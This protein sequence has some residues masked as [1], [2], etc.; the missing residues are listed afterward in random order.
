MK[1]SHDETKEMI[2]PVVLSD[3]FEYERDDADNEYISYLDKLRN[4][5]VIGADTIE[6]FRF[7]IKVNNN[8]EVLNTWLE[9][10]KTDLGNIYSAYNQF[11]DVLEIDHNDEYD[12]KYEEFLETVKEI[13]KDGIYS[14]WLDDQDTPNRDESLTL[15]FYLSPLIYIPQQIVDK[16]YV[17]IILSGM[18]KKDLWESGLEGTIRFQR[19]IDT[20]DFWTFEY[21]SNNEV[22]RPYILNVEHHFPDVYLLSETD[23]STSIS[24][25]IFKAF[26]FYTDTINVNKETIPITRATAS[27]DDDMNQF[28][29]EKEGTF[30]E[31]FMEKFYWM[32]I[33][34][35]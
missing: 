29:Y 9:K 34:S 10:L 24:N 2:R 17:S 27:W 4:L 22:W 28:E 6:D 1:E 31:I 14:E 8:D 7:D 21:D 11:L 18:K 13:K 3:A 20:T 23:D 19:P 25:R 5:I 32:G 33:Q 15:W 35:I 26:F 12:T 16:Y 30:R